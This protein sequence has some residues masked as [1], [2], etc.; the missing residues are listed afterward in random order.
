M[1]PRSPTGKSVEFL[2]GEIHSQN[3]IIQQTLSEDRQASAQ[4]R[5]EVRREL[6]DHSERMAKLEGAQKAVADDVTEIK[7]I[8]IHLEQQRNQAVGAMSLGRWLWTVIAGGAGAG[9]LAGLQWLV[10]GGHKP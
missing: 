8:V 4:Y 9:V 6:K 5:T 1:N 10:N 3:T 2:L 7:P